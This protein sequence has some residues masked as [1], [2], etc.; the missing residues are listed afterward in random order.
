MIVG[1]DAGS[2]PEYACMAVVL[3]VGACGGCSDIEGK[4][5]P[6]GLGPL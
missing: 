1:G 3:L 2:A 5:G 6:Q 4:S